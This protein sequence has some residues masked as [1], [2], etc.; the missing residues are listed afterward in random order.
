MGAPDGWIFGPGVSM[1]N[2]IRSVYKYQSKL[3]KKILSSGL[4]AICVFSIAGCI[5]MPAVDTTNVNRC[6][7]SSDRKTLRIYNA[8]DDAGLYFSV[9][10][11][12]LVPLTGVVSG[13]Y[14]AINNIYNL[15]EERIVCGPLPKE[16]K[17]KT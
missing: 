1:C 17:R 12:I 11:L 5:V 7:I 8:H 10:G 6:E 13:T 2:M 15:G 14:V 4:V 9:S 16:T 3:L